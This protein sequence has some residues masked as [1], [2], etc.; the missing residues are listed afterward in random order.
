MGIDLVLRAIVDL[1]GL[2]GTLPL[3]FAARRVSIHPGSRPASDHSLVDKVFGGG[4]HAGLLDA[5]DGLV[6]SLAGQERIGTER[7]PVAT[8]LSDATEIENGSEDDVGSLGLELLA[9]RKPTSTNELTVPSGGIMR[10]PR[11]TSDEDTYDD[12]AVM[13]PGKVD[14]KSVKRTPAGP[15]C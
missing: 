1:G 6:G 4:L 12:A 14:T 13:P 10:Q 7:L 3:L 2:L 11:A 5:E 9:D 15:S 8:A